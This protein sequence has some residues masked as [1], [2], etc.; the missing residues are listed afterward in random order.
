MAN[1]ILTSI[2]GRKFGLGPQGELLVDHGYGTRLVPYLLANNTAAG[3]AL[4]N[5]TTETALAAATVRANRLQPG[6][7]IQVR[8]GGIATAT[9]STDTLTIKLYIGGIGGTALISMAATDVADNNVFTGE[10]ELAVRT[11][12]STGTIVGQGTFKS[13][14]AAEGTMTIKDDFLA[15]TTLD[16]TADQDITVAGTWSV[17]SASNSCRIDFFRV[18]A[19]G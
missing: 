3:T 4:S 9:N 6:A 8:F 18:V 19:F 15:S 12:G 1:D 11:I 14:P 16:T 5:S 7:L 13:I 2:H 10:Y 17:A